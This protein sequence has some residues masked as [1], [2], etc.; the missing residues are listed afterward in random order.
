[1]TK[2]RENSGLQNDD[3]PSYRTIENQP[4]RNYAPLLAVNK[5]GLSGAN[6]TRTL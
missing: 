1:M 2:G 6:Q 3:P 5:I 4:V